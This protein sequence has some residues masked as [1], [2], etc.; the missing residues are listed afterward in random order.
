[1]CINGALRTPPF[2]MWRGDLQEA[3]E[4]STHLLTVSQPHS[5]LRRSSDSSMEDV[6]THASFASA[7]TV[8][9]TDHSQ[10]PGATQPD[11]SSHKRC[12]SACVKQLC[13]RL[14]AS[15]PPPWHLEYMWIH[16]Q[17]H[18]NSYNEMTL[19]MGNWM[20]MHCS[21]KSVYTIPLK[22][23]SK[24]QIKHTKYK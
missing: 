19:Y 1:M 12:T 17:M 11:S 13:E 9:C 10:T 24:D 16:A 18:G 22:D 14:K 7:L 8:S 5:T 15:F 6:S 21:K 23:S 20:E 4:Y 2:C 3:F